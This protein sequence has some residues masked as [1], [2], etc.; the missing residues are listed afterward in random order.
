MAWATTDRHNVTRPADRGEIPKR[1][2]GF[3]KYKE[4]GW[5]LIEEI[6]R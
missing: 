1:L 4:E 5:E 2:E 6:Q 3:A